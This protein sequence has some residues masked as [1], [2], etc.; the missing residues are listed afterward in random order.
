MSE[1]YSVLHP[2]SFMPNL[3]HKTEEDISKEFTYIKEGMGS[4]VFDKEG[5]NYFYATTAVPSVGLGNP[6]I[7]NA[8]TNQFHKLSFSST[9]GQ[10]HELLQPLT[11]K[12]IE[13]TDNQ[14]SL[15]FY[16]NDG[17]G[18]VETAIKLTR[19]YFNELNQKEKSCF[20]SLDGN[21]HGTTIASGSVTNMGIKEA[22]GVQ[23]PGCFS[24]PFPNMLRPPI[25]GTEDEIVDFC[26]QQLINTIE[27]VG[28][29]KTA[30]IL[31]EPVQGVNGII[32]ANKRYLKEV[33]KI[34]KANNILLIADEVTTGLGRTGYWT[35]SQYY[36]IEPDLLTI[37]KGLTG[38][39][40]PMGVTFM[41]E[42]I[43]NV[44][45]KEGGIFLHGATQCGHPVGCAA[46][47]ELISIIEEDNLLKNAR[48]IG[49]YIKTRL[50]ISL[51]DI[52]NVAEIRGLG[53]MISIE[54]ADKQTRE[55]INFKDGEILSKKLKT[56]G[57][58]GNYFNSILL[59][60]PPLNTSLLD[61]DFVIDNV[62]K[63]FKNVFK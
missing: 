19:Q 57:I 34:A 7:I 50:K 49:Q 27:K 12:L 6:R 25:D 56:Q 20:I 41:T 43:E 30:A 38:G 39:Y 52:P 51:Q 28:P 46:A 11:K 48:D 22:F 14:F 26:L 45:L 58:L 63:A 40:F 16:T 3:K 60:Y 36:G 42:K 53:M 62:T 1:S 61:A 23:I 18:A 17:S 4:W 24:A 59:L 2:F 35:A 13:L 10:M 8:M 5:K 31:V 32:P 15:A 44:L 33:E 29:E 54:L 55:P 47:L 37:S 9:C 21:Y